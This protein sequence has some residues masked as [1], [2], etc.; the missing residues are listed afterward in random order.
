[1]KE[2]YPDDIMLCFVQGFGDGEPYSKSKPETSEESNVKSKKKNK[3]ASLPVCDEE[4]VEL[5]SKKGDGL[6]TGKTLR[7]SSGDQ[8]ANIPEVKR[9]FS[10]RFSVLPDGAARRSARSFLTIRKTW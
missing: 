2:S 9:S 1:M 7:L 6:L 8:P 4:T 5:R 3:R 10:D